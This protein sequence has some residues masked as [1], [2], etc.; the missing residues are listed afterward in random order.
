MSELNVPCIFQ[1]SFTATL[2]HLHTRLFLFNSD[3]VTAKLETFKLREFYE[4][5]SQ[6]RLEKIEY[7]YENLENS[8]KIISSAEA[9]VPLRMH[10]KN[11]Q[12]LCRLLLLWKIPS[13]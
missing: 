2:R 4:A 9:L 13:H 8:E 12:F 10:R 1:H 5:K 3:R 7:F 11:G 6:R